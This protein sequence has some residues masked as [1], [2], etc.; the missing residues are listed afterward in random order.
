M[1]V[2]RETQIAKQGRV[3]V[4]LPRRFWSRQVEIIVLTEPI[5]QDLETAKKSLRGCLHAYA[6]PAFVEREEG[7]WIEA[8]REK[9]GHR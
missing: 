7:A 2:I 6:N 3:Y 1:E 4:Q 9:H 5:D 8:V